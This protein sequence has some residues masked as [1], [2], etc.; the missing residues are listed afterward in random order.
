MSHKQNLHTHTN[1]CDGKDT[2]EAMVHYAIAQGFDSLGFSGHSYMPYS[3]YGGFTEANTAACNQVV[4]ALKEQYRD[5]LP[6]YLGLEVDKYSPIDMTGYD[7]LI[8]SVHYL[9]MNGQYVGFDRSPEVVQQVIDTHFGGDGM[10]F[11]KR[12]YEELARLPEYGP[13]DIIGHFDLITKNLEA[14][15]YFDAESPDYLRYAMD[16]MDA[17]Q[18]KI[19]FF[20]VN[21]GAMA[22]GYRTVPY[23]TVTLLKEL[24]Q[25]GF[26]AMIASDCHDGCYLDCGFAQAAALLAGCGFKE[27]YILTE[28]GFQAVAL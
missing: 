11:A 4:R 15:P 9:N 22:R 10:A 1:F 16:A 21:T 13:F 18:G 20:E 28:N 25:R 14:I 26:G 27:K 23:P 24:K 12:Y 3:P 2:P 6:I 19:P 8:G 17:L 5:I 7:Y